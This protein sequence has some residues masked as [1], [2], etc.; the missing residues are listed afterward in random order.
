MWGLLAGFR[1]EEF[2]EKNRTG[3]PT[4]GRKGM[5]WEGG[6]WPSNLGLLYLFLYRKQKKVGGREDN[7]ITVQR[8]M[9]ENTEVQEKSRNLRDTRGKGGGRGGRNEK[10][11]QK[12]GKKRREKRS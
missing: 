12:K 9:K 8:G 4:T 7:N 2:L 5:L 6:G 1:G 11:Q 10:T 3:R